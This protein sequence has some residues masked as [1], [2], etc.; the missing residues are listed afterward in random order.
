[1]GTRKHCP[2]TWKRYTSVIPALR[3][4]RIGSS[5]PVCKVSKEMKIMKNGRKEGRREGICE[6]HDIS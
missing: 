3:R 2:D 1:L 4:L 5:R 6:Y